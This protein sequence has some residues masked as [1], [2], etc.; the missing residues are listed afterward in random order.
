MRNKFRL[1]LIV[2][3]TVCV[4]L[5][6]CNVCYGR[7]PVVNEYAFKNQDDT[8]MVRKLFQSIEGESIEEKYKYDAKRYLNL[9]VLYTENGLFQESIDCFL[10]A[11]SLYALLN[12][13]DYRAYVWVR[14]C[15]AYHKIGNKSQYDISKEKLLEI[16]EGNQVND[17]EISLI[18]MSQIG[19][20][21]EEDGNYDKALSVYANCLEANERYYG[22]DHPQLFPICYKLASL[23]LR[24]GEMKDASMYII[25][26]G[27][28]CKSHSEDMDHYLSYILLQCELLDK[29]GYVGEAI[30][31]LED[32]I[33]GIN[34]IGNI[35]LKSSF[36]NALSGLYATIGDFEQA[37]KSQKLSLSI[38]EVA[39]GC[40]SVAYAHGLLNIGENYAVVGNY[41]EALQS[42]IKATEIIRA[43]YGSFHP[44]YYNCLHKLA[45]RYQSINLE[46]SK[47][48][49]KECLILSKRLYG[50]NSIE[51]ADELIYSVDPTFNPSDE[52]IE[53]LKKSLDI[54][55]NLGRD[56]DCFY[57]SYL[58]W[59]STLLFVKQDWKSL[60]L[61]SDEILKST[62]AFICL[63]FQRLSL[64]QREMLW[65]TV[66]NALNGLES[67]AAQYSQYA[68]EHS[69]YSLVNDFG[70][71]AYNTRLI[72]KGLLLES[73]KRL[74][75][76]IMAS[77]DTN[78]TQ[79]YHHIEIIKKRLT[80]SDLNNQDILSLKAQL[81]SMERE[82]IQRVAPNG[83]FMDFL[84]VEWENVQAALTSNEVAIEFF[85]Y[86]AQNSIQYGAVIISKNNLA[87]LAFPLFCEDELDKFFIGDETLYDYDSP[88]LY[89]TIWAVLETFSD[90][91]NAKTIY[92]S[93]DKVLNTIAIENLMDYDGQRASDKRRIYRLSSTREIV[94]RH[95]SSLTETSA[96]LYGGLNYD[97][98]L[99]CLN[100][101]SFKSSTE[102]SY[103]NKRQSYTRSLR[104]TYN[105]L[106]GTLDEIKS[107]SCI[108]KHLNPELRSGK[109]GS[110]GSFSALSGHSPSI[111]HLATHGFFFKPEDIE[112][113][114]SEDPQKYQFLNIE[115]LN[116]ISTET[117]A[118]RG[119][120]LL[121]SGA[122]YILKGHSIPD[123]VPDGILTAE[124]VSCLDLKYT[125][126]A[127]L[128]A[129][130]TGLGAVTE[131]GVFGLQR[132]FKLAGVK[133]VLMSLW[134]VDDKIT[135]KLMKLFYENIAK[136]RNKAQAL[137]DAQKKL[138]D[139]P[140]TSQPYFWAGF[141][142]LDGVK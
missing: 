25:R 81:F 77:S 27:G 131:E 19:M 122:N 114:L 30:S 34:R 113:K 49:H 126:L 28:I 38:C 79:I 63:N 15:D 105:N 96:I 3:L 98:P 68:V 64:S 20:F 110:E 132:G 107:I 29:L 92:F 56:F 69:D 65:N 88:G 116:E 53:I 129:C 62:K 23:C 111:I 40:E 75:D 135:S 46:K 33:V 138:R 91:R 137:Y 99:D 21:Y 73:N 11:D 44:E 31:L 142:L 97:A 52:D 32:E 39:T 9:G 76:L 14:L 51:Y 100:D 124:E 58:N 45:V 133:S 78:V 6:V 120:G 108:I 16:S 13:Y 123:S 82:L 24:M 125:E 35:D 8:T 18:V 26:L 112:E 57:L 102:L 139:D 117:Q 90:V 5:F 72:K 74:S 87:P 128:S 95:Q 36:Y 48:L 22:N 41:S 4:I 101:T 89:R 119:S 140:L 37:L 60:L 136:G 104:G 1:E 55:R 10:K 59:Y 134:K 127:V 66:K 86:Q 2:K 141:I 118:M 115:N 93:A 84:S 61:A 42:T 109:N 17:P 94:Y 12:D 106:P 7:L 71:I 70:K 67:Y 121:F 130:E 80:N 83:E 47:D 50:D 85:S 43:K 54:R 103:K